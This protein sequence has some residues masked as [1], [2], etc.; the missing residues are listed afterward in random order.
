MGKLGLNSGYIGSD[1]RL[2]TNG[3]VGYDKY[4]LERRNGRFFPV[5]E[6]DPDAEAFFQRV[7]TAG[8]TLSQTEQFATNQLVLDLKGYNIWSKIKA[9]YPM[10]GASAAACAQ[11]LKSSSF[12]GTFSGGWAYASTGITS[13]GT[14]AFMNTGL[15]LNIMN[16]INDISYG[17]YCRTNN[18]S[19]GSFGWGA[20]GN[21]NNEFWIRYTDVNKYGY[22][23][24]SGNDGGAVS[25]C[26]GWNV[27]SRIASTTKYIQINST[28]DT[29]AS[30]SSGTL[31]SRNFIF[32]QGSQGF[33]ARENALGFIGDG[34]TFSEMSNLYT[35]V[36]AFQTT[37][38][39][40]V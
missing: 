20:G 25:D 33:E 38:S 15:N 32:A 14:N 28:I 29:Y 37:L 36:Q 34:I 1:Q 8:G 40:Q 6:G 26:R 4:Y 17:Y 5:L 7:V 23:F 30:V 19:L 16:S 9:I 31:I 39:R 3:V 24:D 12:T 27:M 2:T 35:A 10:V 18:L 11:N 21:I 22:L 13:N